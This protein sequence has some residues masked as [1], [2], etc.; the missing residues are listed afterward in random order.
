[1]G[2]AM[3]HI[4][5][6]WLLLWGLWFS[7]RPVHMVFVVDSVA[8][9][10]VPLNTLIFPCHYLPT[11]VPDSFIHPSLM[12]NNLSTCQHNQ[13]RSFKKEPV[14]DLCT[15]YNTDQFMEDRHMYCKVKK[16]FTYPVIVM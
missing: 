9:G 14:L 16:Y 2:H 8:L 10:Q 5:G 1:M 15:Q 6:Q 11:H 4:V 12:V 7:P 3:A 13:I